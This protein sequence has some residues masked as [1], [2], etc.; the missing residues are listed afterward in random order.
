[1][2]I[3]PLLDKL[4]FKAEIEWVKYVEILMKS[5]VRYVHKVCFRGSKQLDLAH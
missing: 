4:E 3:G 2:R 5:G 1:M